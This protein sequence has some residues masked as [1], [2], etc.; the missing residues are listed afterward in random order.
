MDELY[1][2]EMHMRAVTIFVIVLVAGV[3]QVHPFMVD[4]D[5]RGAQKAAR[6]SNMLTSNA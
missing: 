5:D 6:L 3:I 4:A 1:A 2:R